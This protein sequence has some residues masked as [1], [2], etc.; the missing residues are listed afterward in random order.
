[1]KF[2]FVYTSWN[3]EIKYIV[4]AK[5]RNF[6]HRLAVTIEMKGLSYLSNETATFMEF[7]LFQENSILKQLPWIP[8]MKV[9]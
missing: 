5:K 9:K 4:K 6:Q 3:G 2:I 1:M 8:I 7:F